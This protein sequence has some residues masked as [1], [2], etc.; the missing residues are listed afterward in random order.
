[1][2]FLQGEN[3]MVATNIDRG[4]CEHCFA[5]KPIVEFRRRSANGS[6]RLSQCRACHNAAERQR[7]AMS[8]D[9]SDRRKMRMR[10]VELKNAKSKRHVEIVAATMIQQF[11]G[12]P[13]FAGQFAS[14]FE[15]AKHERGL[16]ALRC[17][18]AL[19]RLMEHADAVRAAERVD[20]GLLSDEDLQREAIELT[21]QS[22]REDPQLV[23]TAAQQLGCTVIP[24]KGGV[25]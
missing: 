2:A 15:R 3:P 12:L 11:G 6:A 16:G 21:R 4:F 25:Q 10:L 19:F 8:R 23:I 20:L 22:L 17:F 18:E 5:V 13:G 9:K 1:M 14:F 7:R 24:P